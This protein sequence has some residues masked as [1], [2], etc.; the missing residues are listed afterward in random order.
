MGMEVAG[1]SG[2]AVSRGKAYAGFSDGTVA[3][4][5][6]LTGVERWSADLAAEVEAA[7]GEAPRYLDVDTTPIPD[8]IVAG[9]VVFVASYSGGAFA[10]DAETGTQVWSN[11]AVLGVSDLVSW[12]EPGH[13][14]RSG[15]I[16]PPRRLL[17]AASGTSGLWALDPE[18]GSEVWRRAFPS[19][20]VSAPVPIAGALLVSTTRLGVFLLSPSGGEVI[21]GIHMVDGSAMT[22]AA[23]GTRAFVLTNGG[24]L[25]ALSV[26]PPRPIRP[27]ERLPL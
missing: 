19:G 24:S 7:T 17:L 23:L 5:D 4:F 2:V 3:A 22:P 15:S 12:S 11:P 10:L 6:T 21:D 16:V 9:P 1:H 26:D 18:D 14:S 8:T 13:T 20:G 27:M 25:L